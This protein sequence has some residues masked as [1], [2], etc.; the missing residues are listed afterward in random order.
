MYYFIKESALFSDEGP[1][2]RVCWAMMKLDV[3]EGFM[4][5]KHSSFFAR[6]SIVIRA[7]N[8]KFCFYVLMEVS[9]DELS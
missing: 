9:N 2:E 4:V 5:S 8:A 7:L 6:S 1:S 3:A